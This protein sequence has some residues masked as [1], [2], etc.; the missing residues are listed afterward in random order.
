[1]FD[2]CLSPKAPSVCDA[3]CSPIEFVESE[4]SVQDEGIQV[5]AETPRP[6]TME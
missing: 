1:M 6:K 5:S 3:V 4:V 2:V